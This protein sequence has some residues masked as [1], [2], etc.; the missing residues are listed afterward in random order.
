MARSG[1]GKTG[2]GR[3]SGRGY[4]IPARGG[5][6]HP[7]FGIDGGTAKSARQ[8]RRAEEAEQRRRN[9]GGR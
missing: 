4:F 5:D 3:S 6:R 2:R 1:G 7:L 8:K 9:R